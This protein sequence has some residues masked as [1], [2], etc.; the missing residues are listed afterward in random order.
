M[1]PLQKK[2][3]KKKNKLKKRNKLKNN[4]LRKNKLRKNRKKWNKLS[5]FYLGIKV[6]KLSV[7]S[8]KNMPFP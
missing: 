1:T 7:F 5:K 3:L 2:E 4:K 8:L 6:G